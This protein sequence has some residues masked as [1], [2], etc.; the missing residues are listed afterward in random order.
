MDVNVDQVGVAHEPDLAR[1][2]HQAPLTVPLHRLTG[3][4]GSGKTTVPSRLLH[5]PG[6]ERIAVLVNEAGDLALDHWLLER[7]DEEVLALTSGCACCP[8][9]WTRPPAASSG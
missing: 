1:S 8:A 5:N 6:G 9:S 2:P 4:L 7:V 3:F